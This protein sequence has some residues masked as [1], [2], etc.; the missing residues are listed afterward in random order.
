MIPLA[1][2]SF[3]IVCGNTVILK[4]SER[5]PSAALFIADVWKQAGLPDGVLNVANGDKE[6]VDALLHHPKVAGIVFVGSTR[7]AQYIYEEASQNRKRVAA[8]GGGKNHMVIM[9]D[10]DIDQA[11]DAFISAAYGSASQRCMAI[12]VA[13]PVGEKTA[14]EFVSKVKERTAQLKVG[15]YDDHKA[16]FGAL[17]TRHSKEH[18]ESFIEESIQAGAELCVDGR[19]LVVKGY[20]QGFYTG[21]TLLDK[22]TPEMRVYREEVFGP[23]RAVVRVST[24]NEA[25]KL[26][27]D[28]E[29][30][31]G[32]TI[33][34]RNGF[35]ARQ[36]VENIEVGMVGVNVGVPIPV[37]Y[38]N[39]GGWKNSKFGEGHLLGPDAI[40]FYT[41][42]KTV[43]ERWT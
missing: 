23:V 1:M 43:S 39:F 8:F 42:I 35:T 22:V 37:P 5:V 2:T 33:F 27:N 24:L 38:H 10:A 6:A 15:P 29:Y 3:A 30:G 25:M 28:H 13:V 11:V 21:A 17:I 20:E 16:D 19:N 18:V 31:N 32:V 40:R 26:I 34:T 4:P 9:P 41:K 36:F 7:V 14:E 12:S